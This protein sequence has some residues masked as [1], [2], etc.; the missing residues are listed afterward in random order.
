MYNPDDPHVQI[1]VKRIVKLTMIMAMVAIARNIVL[2]YYEQYASLIE[3]LVP[4][5]DPVLWV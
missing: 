4:V 3:M 5:D 1:L 2:L